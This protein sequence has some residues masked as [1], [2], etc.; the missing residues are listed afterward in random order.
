MSGAGNSCSISVGTC[1]RVTDAAPFS[2][3]RVGGGAFAR[4][5]I[6]ANKA[7]FTLIDCLLLRGLP[8]EAPEALHVVKWRSL[9][10]PDDAVVSASTGR[11]MRRFLAQFLVLAGLGAVLSLVIAYGLVQAILPLVPG[12]GEVTVL[13]SGP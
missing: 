11:L 2:R 5:A 12:Q 3:A 1:G 4:A 8:V 13:P 10:H 6:G 7:I 9:K